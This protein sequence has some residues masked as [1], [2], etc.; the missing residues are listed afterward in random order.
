MLLRILNG[1]RWR[2]CLGG[3]TE[4]LSF[5]VR[6]KAGSVFA[7]ERGRAGDQPIPPVPGSSPA[8]ALYGR[9]GMGGNA[10]RLHQRRG[11]ST[12]H[13][14]RPRGQQPTADPAGGGA[15]GMACEFCPPAMASM[16]G[17]G[18]GGFVQWRRRGFGN[19]RISSLYGVPAALWN[20]GSATRP[21]CHPLG[22]QSSGGQLRLEVLPVP[23]GEASIYLAIGRR[24]HERRS[25]LVNV[26][27]DEIAALRQ[28]T[29]PSIGP[30]QNAGLPPFAPQ[31]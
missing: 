3:Y 13:L 8:A 4:A 2:R 16:P 10:V 31:E 24:F 9:S 7:R 19:V 28:T 25:H 17:G 23:F 21:G 6:T 14:S 30:L 20:G 5:F 22:G 12:L 1:G 18:G 26:I 15:P 11:F 29:G 27:W